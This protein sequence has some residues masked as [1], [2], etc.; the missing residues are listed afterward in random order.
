MSDADVE[1]WEER[2][3]QYLSGE[4][5]AQFEPDDLLADHS[6][7]FPGNGKA[8]D[9]ATGL[10]ANALWLA[11]QG[12]ATSAVDCSNTG[13]SIL[14]TEAERRNVEVTTHAVDLD[15]WVWPDNEF[16]VVCVFRF[17]NRDIF[18]S[19]Q[20]SLKPGGLLVYQTFN[21]NFLKDKPSFNPSY[22]L[23]DN[24]LNEV[25]DSFEIIV[26]DQTGKSTRYIARKS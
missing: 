15:R 25:F 24:E 3:A 17:L 13:L 5:T 16:D 9:V 18:A 11:E 20:Q 12:Y 7:L 8:L 14:Q 4:K 10:G 22:V 21:Q 2:Y 19:I 1:R 23:G 26:N 6:A